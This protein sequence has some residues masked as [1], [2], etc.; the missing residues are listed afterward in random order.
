MIGRIRGI[1][2]E[3]L[4]PWLVVD[5]MGVGYQL[6]APMST[7]YHLPETGKEINLYTHMIVREDVLAL[8][9]FVTKEECALFQEFIKING[10]GAKAAL[11]L[12]SGMST[13]DLK[14]TISVQDVSRL[15]KIPGIG[16][17][18]A[19]RIIVE[20]QDKHKKWQLPSDNP[21][22]Q[23]ENFAE[24]AFQ[25]AIEALVALGYKN[26]EAEKAVS[27]VSDQSLACEDIIRIALQGLAK[28]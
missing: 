13:A 17:K 10:I 25:Q 9:G 26:K 16:P 3:K 19:Q 12:L 1:L 21:L 11:A 8:Y 5:V 4:P 2:I 18:T 24:S 6:Q 28:A 20:C 27:K 23:G 22:T 7:F 15:Q 14:T